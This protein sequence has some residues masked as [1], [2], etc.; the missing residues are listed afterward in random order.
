MLRSTLSSN[1]TWVESRAVNTSL[2]TGCAPQW[3]TRRPHKISFCEQSWGAFQS[4][5]SRSMEQLQQ[6]EGTGADRI[7][8][9]DGEVTIQP[10]YG[11]KQ[12]K[13]K[14]KKKGWVCKSEPQSD[15]RKD[16]SQSPE[17]SGNP[18]SI[19]PADRMLSPLPDHRIATCVGRVTTTDGMRTGDR[20]ISLFPNG[21][22]ARGN[23]DRSPVREY[24]GAQ[25][26]L[27]MSYSLFTHL[28]S[29]SDR[30]GR[31]LVSRFNFHRGRAAEEF[32][33]RA[34]G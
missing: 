27:A 2:P 24:H 28:P 29:Y 33:L 32:S 30:R 25:D 15:Q 8:L 13:K 7:P 6:T 9:A 21:A 11:E 18:R 5:S 19:S 1:Q 23:R 22:I 4:G 34:Q 12:K 14:K 16:G 10:N 17:R 3:A 31:A 26:C 20:F